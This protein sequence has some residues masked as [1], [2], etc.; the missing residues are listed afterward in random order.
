MHLL[1]FDVA[2]GRRRRKSKNPVILIDEVI[3]LS[4]VSLQ[5]FALLMN[6]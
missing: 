1:W 3:Q 6:V 5:T 2:G 4:E